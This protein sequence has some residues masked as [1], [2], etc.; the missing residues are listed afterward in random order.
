MDRF[1][2]HARRE[3]VFLALGTMDICVFAPLFVVLLSSIVPT[4]PVA[5]TAILLG[6]VL[7]VHYLARLTLHLSLRPALRSSLLGTG[8]LV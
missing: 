7:A 5:L 1:H 8:V 3:L 2:A 4:Q 6:A